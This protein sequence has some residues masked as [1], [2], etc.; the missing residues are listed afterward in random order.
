MCYGVEYRQM[1]TEIQNETV[2]V[3]ESPVELRR[4]V[5]EWVEKNREEILKL[6][7]E[8]KV[9]FGR[10]IGEFGFLGDL[11]VPL[12]DDKA[13][14]VSE[15]GLCGVV[16][17][18][19]NRFPLDGFT[20]STVYVYGYCDL[21]SGW[22]PWHKHDVLRDEN[23]MICCLTPG[24]LILD[25]DELKTMKDQ[26]AG[27]SYV[28]GFEDETF[29][30]GDRLRRLEHILPGAVKVFDNG[31]GTLCASRQV[32]DQMLGIRLVRK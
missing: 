6:M 2:A 28:T 7:D 1:R 9:K 11:A 32:I 31:L 13:R 21:R 20:K 19:I 30:P 3:L 15:M 4:R 16:G 25:G 10:M 29:G 18:V 27:G 23:G 26:G 8:S 22:V 17:D 14:T 12:I 5:F 24:Q